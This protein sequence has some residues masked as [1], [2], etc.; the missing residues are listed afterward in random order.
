MLYESGKL[1]HSNRLGP[2]RFIAFHEGRDIAD[3]PRT[4]SSKGNLLEVFGPNSFPVFLSKSLIRISSSLTN[5]SGGESP[6][7]KHDGFINISFRKRSMVAVNIP[8]LSFISREYSL[9][10]MNAEGTARSRRRSSQRAAPLYPKSSTS[11][12]LPSLR[13]KQRFLFGWLT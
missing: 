11:F 13:L 12:E 8:K 3:E 4:L 1:C 6:G 10:M 7:A 2:V 5:S 9:E